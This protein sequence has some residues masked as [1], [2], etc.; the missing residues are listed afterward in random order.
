[1]MKSRFCLVSVVM[2]AALS[3]CS[4]IDCPLN[5]RVMAVFRMAGTAAPL[6]DTLTV[7]TTL[8]EAEGNDTVL[9]NRVTDADSIKLPMSYSRTSDTYIFSL[10]RKGAAVTV[11]DTVRV[12]K[13]NIPHFESVDCNPSMFHTVQSV[14]YTRNAIDSIK[15]N[16]EQVTFDVVKPHFLIYFKGSGD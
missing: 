9:V 6:A 4:S 10:I 15:I 12:R 2:V 7:S 1:M 16:N 11:T 8:S 5:N 14:D 3:A 13:A